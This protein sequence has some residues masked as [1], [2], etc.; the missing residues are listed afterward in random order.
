MAGPVSPPPASNAG[1]LRVYAISPATRRFLAALGTWDRLDATRLAP[2]YDMRIYGDRDAASRLSFGAYEAGIESLATIVEHGELMRA[3]DA[4]VVDTSVERV[5]ALATVGATDDAIDV[6]AEGCVHRARLLIVADGAASPTRD[7]LG[8]AVDA[9]PYAQRGVVGNFVVERAH[10]GTAFQWFT[11]E[12]VVALLPLP[13][14]DGRPAMSLVWSAPDAIADALL[15]AG[16]ASI[17]ARLS[18][19]AHAELGSLTAASA[20]KDFPLTLQTA[21]ASTARRAVLVGDA[22]HVVHPLAGQGLNLG[23]QDVE[24]LVD[25]LASREAFRDCGDARVV[26]RYRRARIEPVFLMR[27]ATDGLARLFASRRRDVSWLRSTGL[28]LVDRTPVLKRLLVRHASGSAA[29]GPVLRS[30]R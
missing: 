2:V 26:A 7:A 4:A 24:V 3:L 17:A 10:A 29:A 22:A 15:A 6:Q 28:A 16:P 23:L 11:D 14:I 30:S 25:V 12:G 18:V 21:H 27:Q 20:S 1:D 8:I 19:L 13:E 9:R 5:D